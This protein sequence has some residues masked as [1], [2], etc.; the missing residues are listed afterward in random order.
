MYARP[1]LGGNMITVQ[2]VAS[3]KILSGVAA[4]NVATSKEGDP[5]A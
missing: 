3:K 1:N 2:L 4:L 5:C